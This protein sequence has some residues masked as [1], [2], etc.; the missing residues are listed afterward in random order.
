VH[1]A[2]GGQQAPSPEAE[3]PGGEPQTL[4]DA[5]EQ[6]A[7]PASA[8]R[9]EAA[10]RR[11]QLREVE[12]ERDAIR[13][14]RDALRAQPCA[15]KVDAR[16]RQ[17]AERIAGGADSPIRLL[18]PADL[19]LAGFELDAFCENGTLDPAR[20]RAAVAQIARERPHW[21]ETY[22]FPSDGG[23]GYPAP[24]SGPSMWQ[25]MKDARRCQ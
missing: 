6:Q 18:H 3:E 1:P 13:E 20:V 11:R 4:R 8:L 12:A 9:R 25:A 19:W 7:D 17:D 16:D 22:Q 21:A 10:A 24:S 14:E 2:Q 15:R 5:I 23:T